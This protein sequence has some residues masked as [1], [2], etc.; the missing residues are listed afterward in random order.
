ME[1]TMTIQRT[2]KYIIAI[3]LFLSGVAEAQT[4]WECGTIGPAEDYLLARGITEYSPILD[5]VTLRIFIH[6]INRTNGTGGL[7]QPEVD[8]AIAIMRSDFA[9]R[10]IYFYELGR[11]AINNDYY[12]NFTPERFDQLIQVN[13]H[14][15]AIDV[16]LLP[17]SVNY[18]G[19]AADIPST[20]FVVDGSLSQ[21]SVISHEM[22]HCLGLWHTHSGR[23]CGDFRN[24]AEAINGSNCATCGDLV[25]DTPADPCL[26]GIVNALCQYTG[27]PEFS[28]DVSNIMSYTRPGCMTHFT[29]GQF[30]RSLTMIENSPILQAVVIP[31][32]VV[33][34]HQR[35]QGSTSSVDSIARWEAGSQFV[36]YAA[37]K[38]FSF[39][40]GTHEVLRGAQKI[41]SSQKYNK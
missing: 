24:C 10:E 28:P 30:N 13:S 21:T 9:P 38:R 29:T 32:E 35:L 23:G 8:N 33:W 18:G 39:S 17:M 2:F 27:P 4:D 19:R 34:L 36:T 3:L 6:V 25:C 12:F 11:G 14:T 37:P 1:D 31:D 22:G 20:A 5:R 15:N 16:Y 26:A 41:I 7:S 40:V